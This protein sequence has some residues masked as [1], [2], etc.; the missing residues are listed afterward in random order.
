MK[1]N[2]SGCFF[3]E[4][5]VVNFQPVA[6]TANQSILSATYEDSI[7]FAVESKARPLHI[8]R[9]VRLY[10]NDLTIHVYN[11]NLLLMK[12]PG[13]SRRPRR[14]HWVVDDCQ[15]RQVSRG[16]WRGGAGRG[17]PL[18]HGEGPATRPRRPSHHPALT[19]V[20]TWSSPCQLADVFL[21]ST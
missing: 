9:T 21:S 15:H 16:R 14:H 6:K 19:T 1:E 10:D 18:R 3:S 2:A 8:G 5:S 20:Y 12:V 13:C 4:H 17:R 7:Q 11:A